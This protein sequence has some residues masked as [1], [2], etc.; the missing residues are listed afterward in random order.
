MTTREDKKQW[1]IRQGFRVAKVLNDTEGFDYEAGPAKQ[2]PADVILKSSSGKYPDREAQIVSIPLDFRSRDDKGT[3]EKLRTSLR[4]FL[5]ARKL[6]HLLVGVI[7]SSRTEMGGAPKHLVEKL[8]EIIER[9]GSK[10]DVHLKY[11]DLEKYDPEVADMV[12]FVNVSHHPEIIEGVEID[13]PA[14]GAVP[15]DGQWIEEGIRKKLVKYGGEDAVKSLAL[16][17]GVA[18]FVD[19]RQVNA[20]KKTFSEANLPFAEIWINTEFHGTY[21][22]KKRS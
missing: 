19:D 12:H 8:A 6:R 14:G 9:E 18:G 5:T 15:I 16:I 17:I 22:L 21:C 10:V 4:D 1:E 2:E 20:F 7:P 11:E 3:I 13:I